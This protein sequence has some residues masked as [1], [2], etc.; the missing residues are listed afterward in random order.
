MQPISAGVPSR[1]GTYYTTQA[2]VVNYYENMRIVYEVE[3]RVREIKRTVA[4][5]EPGRRIAAG[6]TARQQERHNTT[7]RAEAGAQLQPDG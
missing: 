5:A 6:E 7:A 4:P 1:S 3:S 2:R